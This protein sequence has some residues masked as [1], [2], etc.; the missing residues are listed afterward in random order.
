M[1][2]NIGM[3]KEAKEYYTAH[4]LAEQLSFNVMTIYRYI[5]AKK[6]KAYKLGKEYR[7]DKTEFASFLK[8]V[9]NK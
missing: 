3:A 2:N 5:K 4:E 6:L 9:S 7:I 1:I 8:R